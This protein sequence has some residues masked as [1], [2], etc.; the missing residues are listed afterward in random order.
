LEVSSYAIDQSG[1]LVTLDGPTL[2]HYFSGQYTIGGINTGV[3]FALDGSGDL[4]SIDR[5]GNLAMAAS[6]SSPLQQIATG[7]T[8]VALD[9]AGDL[10]YLTGPYTWNYVLSSGLFTSGSSVGPLGNPPPDRF[11]LD[12]NGNLYELAGGVLTV[13]PTSTS[14]PHE[15]P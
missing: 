3:Q 1:E 2:Y 5:N 10:V 6:S 9:S 12:L 8:Q 4:Y 13:A 15:D 11:A 7:V 14:T